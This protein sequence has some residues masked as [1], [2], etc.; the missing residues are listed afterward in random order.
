M[1]DK[2]I[3]K[4]L[5]VWLTE[6]TAKELGIEEKRCE[7]VISWTYRKTTE[8]F[9]DNDSIE[10][11]GFGKYVLSKTKIKRRIKLCEMAIN[12]HKNRISKLTDDGAIE[13]G[14]KQIRAIEERMNYL[15]LRLENEM[16]RNSGRMEKR[17]ISSRGTKT[18]D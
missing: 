4:S 15:K 13:K 9:Q 11:S 10:L 8:A 18:V 5:V 6:L 16:E 7:T 3:S 2:P 17:F 12:S 1:A 14:W